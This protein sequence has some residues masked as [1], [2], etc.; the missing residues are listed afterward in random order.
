VS[1]AEKPD[2]NDILG[3]RWLRFWVNPYS[4]QL[5]RTNLEETLQQTE[6][7]EAASI[8]ALEEETR[9]LYVGITRPRDYLVFPT[10]VKSTKWLNRVFNEG[11]EETPTLD[12]DTTETPF[13]HNNKALHCETEIT[14]KPREWG[15]I[16]AEETITR[17]SR[18]SQKGRRARTDSETDLCYF[19]GA[20][21]YQHRH[22][23][24]P[25]HGEAGLSLP[26]N[27]IRH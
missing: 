6:E 2:L 10:T 14:Y 16:T 25:F 7:W 12:P 13:Y 1:E 23:A 18:E 5:A 8:Q 9:L 19:G 21:R 24:S 22:G 17:L 27:I 11:N 15:E 26:G 20:G 4:D 3:N